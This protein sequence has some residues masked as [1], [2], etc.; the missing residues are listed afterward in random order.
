MMADFVEKGRE[1]YS[2]A[3]KG[4]TKNN[5]AVPDIGKYVLL[6]GDPNRIAMMAGQ[7]DEG[8]KE[9]ELSR[10]FRAATGTYKGSHIAAMSTG[11]GGASLENPFM[12]LAA[13][14]V[15]TFIRVGTTGTLQEHI[16][17]GDVIINDSNVRLDG[18][19]T[20]YVRPEYPSAADPIV[21]MAL[22]QAAEDLGLTYHVGTGCTAASYFAGQSRPAY[23]GYK[24]VCADQDLHDL[25]IA[26]VLNFE[27]EGAALITL[28]RLFGFRA[29]MCAAVV[30]NR[31]TGEFDETQGQE[32][33]CMVGAEAIHILTEWDEKAKAAGKRYFFPGLL[34]K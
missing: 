14:G 27:M 5:Y 12:G 19:S 13:Q 32:K 24:R 18:L 25:K 28:A 9:Y 8:A 29:G 11:I 2:D 33:A 10:G 31:I 4:G 21:T 15:D 23:G 7:W 17:V 30:A 34:Q 22:I 1:N 6:P 3:D 26:N 16:K 20:L